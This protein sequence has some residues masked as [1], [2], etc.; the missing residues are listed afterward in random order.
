MS[1]KDEPNWLECTNC[2]R[3]CTPEEA[4][5]R[6]FNTGRCAVC[7][8]GLKP[9]VAP[10][11]TTKPDTQS[12]KTVEEIL[13]GYTRFVY[14]KMG[15]SYIARSDRLTKLQAIAALT[16]REKRVVQEAYYKGKSEGRNDAM[17]AVEQFLAGSKQ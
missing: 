17:R 15:G 9:F 7:N 11:L 13:E 16:A 5:Q 3:V 14:F 1:S 2:G 8:G 12:D 6:N 10:Q 4:E